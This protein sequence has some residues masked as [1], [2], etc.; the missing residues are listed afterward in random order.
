[1]VSSAFLL[2]V[3]LKPI[4]KYRE[5]RAIFVLLTQKAVNTK[6]ITLRIFPE[7]LFYLLP[8]F[9]AGDCFLIFV[10]LFFIM[11]ADYVTLLP[12]TCFTFPGRKS[13]TAV[14]AA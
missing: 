12:V 6:N 3:F 11:D 7:G 5:F 14:K 4:L 9:C 1:M 8:A 2:I 13:E 10:T